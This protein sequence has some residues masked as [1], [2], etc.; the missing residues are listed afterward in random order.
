MIARDNVQ[1]INK[2]S[3]QATGS[4]LM[5]TT[6]DGSPHVR[7]TGPLAMVIDA[8]KNVITGPLITI[9]PKQGIAHVVGAGTMH[10]LQE[11]ADGSKPRPMDVTWTDRADMN[12]PANRVD[13]LGNVLVKTLNA[14]GATDTATSDR[15]RIDLV[16]KPTPATRPSTRPVTATTQPTTR[17]ATH[18]TMADAMQ[19]DVM[20]DKEVRTITLDGH[21]KVTSTTLAPDGKVL[22]QF[23]LDAPTIISQL[24]GS[25]EQPGKTLTVPTS[26]RMLVGD[27][28]PPEKNAKVGTEKSA[29]EDSAGSRGNTAFR[30]SK[31]L[32]YSEIDKRATMTGDVFIVHW[33]DSDTATENKVRIN[34]DQ[35]TAWFEP[36]KA[37]SRHPARN[38]G[39][40]AGAAGVMPVRRLQLKRLTADGHVVITR[41][42]GATLTS[43]QIEYD[44]LSHWMAARGTDNQPAAL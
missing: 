44:P 31:Q 30:W 24:T 26:G 14:D 29:D 7:L 22:R 8:K 5:I 1:V 39:L 17:P 27:H 41:D 18:D 12:G 20:K 32:V 16:K 40:Q 28:R 15:V 6:Y 42:S 13:V 37:Q 25:R 11:Q 10:V 19:M 3:S 9:E 43:Q 2:E 34:A 36:Q 33:P 23:V 38:P 4:E 21:A 35:V